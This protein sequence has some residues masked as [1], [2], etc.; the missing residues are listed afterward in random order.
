MIYKTS[1]TRNLFF[2]DNPLN[3]AV[4]DVLKHSVCL[5]SAV[6]KGLNMLDC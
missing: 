3:P 4:T 1:E 2:I 6:Q 5:L